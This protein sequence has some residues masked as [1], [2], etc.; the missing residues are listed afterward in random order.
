MLQ[1][2]FEVLREGGLNLVHLNVASILGAR[3]FEMLRQQLENSNVDVFCASETWLRSLY[4]QGW[5]KL[6]DINVPEWTGPGSR[7]W[8]IRN[9]K[10]DRVV[11]RSSLGL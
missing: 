1:H 9:I 10:M 5:L 8:G 6:K 7:T 4:R 2:Q 3:K 11:R